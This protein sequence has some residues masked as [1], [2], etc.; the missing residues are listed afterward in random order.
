[1]ASKAAEQNDESVVEKIEDETDKPIA[2]EVKES[3]VDY[4]LKTKDQVGKQ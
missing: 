3:T 1:M 2:D 4:Y